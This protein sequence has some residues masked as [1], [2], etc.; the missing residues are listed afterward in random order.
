MAK[1]NLTP[2]GRLVRKHR[3]DQGML[4]KEMADAL[5]MA[6]S[7]LSAIETGRK[8]ISKNLPQRVAE[9]LGLDM[10]ESAA[11]LEAA[12]QSVATH[13]IRDVASERRDVAAALARRFNELS[14]DEIKD[15]RELLM[16][17]TA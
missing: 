14:E 16:R 5:G 17:R 10:E 4:L 13:T 6:S 2:F 1:G 11:L 15:I 12:E 3:I 7:W 9:V 8:P